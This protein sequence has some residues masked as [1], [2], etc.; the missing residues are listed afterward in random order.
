MVPGRRSPRPLQGADDEQISVLVFQI[1]R[2]LLRHA[3]ATISVLLVEQGRGEVSLILKGSLDDQERLTELAGELGQRLGGKVRVS[4]TVDADLALYLGSAK[5]LGLMPPMANPSALPPLLPLGMLPSDQTL[6]ANW[7]ELGNVLIAAMPGGGAE[8][9]LT[10]LLAN[11]VTRRSPKHL[12]LCTIVDPRTVSLQLRELPHQRAVVDSSSEVACTGL[13][14]DLRR[15]LRRRMQ[16]AGESEQIWPRPIDNPE[17]VLV[18][19]EIA[20]LPNEDSTLEFIATEGPRHGIRVVASTVQ[21]ATLDEHVLGHFRTR[22]ILQA[23]D[24]DEG[25]HVLGLPEAAD[26]GSGELLLRIDRRQPKRLRGFRIPADRVDQLVR[27]MREA[28]G[29]AVAERGEQT[30]DCAPDAAVGP[31]KIP[32]EMVP[33]ADVEQGSQSNEMLRS[34]IAEPDDANEGENL[35]SD[36]EPAAVAAL[37]GHRQVHAEVE[38]LSETSSEPDARATV[39]RIDE[40]QPEESAWVQIQCFGDFVVRSGDRE[41][42]PSGEE[43][44]SYKAWEV[45]AFL[46]CQ[47]GGAVSKEKLLTAMWPDVGGERV[48]NRLHAALVRLRALLARQVPSI[49]SDVVRLDRDGTCRLN[50]S[51]VATD[52]HEFVSLLRTVTGLATEGAIAALERVR[53]LY[54]GDLLSS[55]GAREYEWVVDRDESGVTLREHYRE[56]YR[57]A[58]KR[59]ARLYREEERADRAVPLLKELLQAEPTLEDVVRDLYQCFRDLGDLSSLLREDRH[60]RQAL[61]DAYGSLDGSDAEDVPPE[62]ETEALFQEIRTEFNSRTAPGPRPD[63]G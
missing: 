39:G 6:H 61:R 17:L 37:N 22:L 28:Y 62:P 54:K 31:V 44:A 40:A 51:L 25:V 41:I 52:V 11:L 7:Q 49:P 32:A 53:S 55:R 21:A 12:Q 9:V 38:M 24:D 47:P 57:R 15:E 1:Q 26:L 48:T 59:L 4:K 33:N 34:N 5:L 58:T 36:D 30:A 43:G 3:L 19:G 56:E 13:L 35:A 29:F 14:E 10:S 18:V 23:F 63:V 2:F 20:D 8:V 42:S 27:Q 60:L 16:A 45:L 46:A 50:T